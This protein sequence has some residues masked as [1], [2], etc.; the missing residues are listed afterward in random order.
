M[1]NNKASYIQEILNDL[2]ELESLGRQAAHTF[3]KNIA[4]GEMED[5][6]WQLLSTLLKQVQDIAS[7]A[8]ITSFVLRHTKPTNQ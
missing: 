5:E 4:N 6:D 7:S 3:V 8:R 2:Q 1:S